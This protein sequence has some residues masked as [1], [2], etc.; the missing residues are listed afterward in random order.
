MHNEFLIK[1]IYGTF[2]CTIIS[3]KSRINKIY[4]KKN[5]IDYKEIEVPNF[6]LFRALSKIKNISNGLRYLSDVIISKKIRNKIDNCTDLIEFMD[7]HTEGYS[8][9]RKKRFRKAIIIIRSHTPWTILR[10]YYTK[11]EKKGVDSWLAFKKEKFCFN[12]CDAIT[13][14]SYDLKN[15]LM[16]VFK[17]NPEKITVIPNLI[18]T[19]HFKPLNDFRNKKSAQISIS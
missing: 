13:T 2:N 7:I 14:P 17:I 15:K 11:N 12:N 19:N 16:K 6:F 10:N 9:I 1:A 4:Y 5:K 8:Y 18:D 3:F